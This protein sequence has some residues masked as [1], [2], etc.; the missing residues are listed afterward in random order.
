MLSCS[1]SCW[2][3]CSTFSFTFSTFY[4]CFCFKHWILRLYCSLISSR[5][6]SSYYA[7]SCAISSLTSFYI[8]ILRAARSWISAVWAD[9]PIRSPIYWLAW[10]RDS[11]IDIS[12][13]TSVSSN[14]VKASKS[15]CVGWVDYWELL[16]L[17]PKLYLSWAILLDLVG[18]CER[19]SCSNS[20]RV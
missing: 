19:T 4:A 20:N 9:K 10:R 15:S 2:C 13:R 8:S 3:S 16:L 11:Y 18:L 12:Y 1:S 14:Y 17:R 6:F 7:I 5:S